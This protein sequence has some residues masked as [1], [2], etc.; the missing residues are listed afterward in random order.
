MFFFETKTKA[1]SLTNFKILHQNIASVLSKQE[2]LEVT[3]QE[4]QKAHNGPDV[5]CL[6]ETFLIKDHKKH[7]NINAYEIAASFC[8]DKQRGGTC[9]LVRKGY[10]INELTYLKTYANEKIFEVCGIELMSHKLI[11]ICLYRTPS[12]DPSVFLNKLD[13]LLHNL[14]KIYKYKINIVIAGDFN[15]N[16]LIKG[17]ITNEL[18]DLSKTYNLKI[19]IDVPTRKSS[20]IDHILSNISD[21]T[22]TVLPLH[23]SDH[24]TAQ[25]LS[26]PVG[27][28][29]LQSATYFIYK[30]DYSL[31]NIRKF[32]ECLQNLSWSEVYGKKDLNIAFSTFHELLCLFYNLCFPKIRIKVHN[33][34]KKKQNWIS[35]GII[36]SCK[37]NGYYGTNIIKIKTRSIKLNILHILIY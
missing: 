19:H 25:L 4:L 21:A 9:I 33:H 23:L 12:S 26:F 1:T 28:K 11:I 37:K 18:Q 17:K 31:D 7:L 36:R 10:P 27:Y 2:I 29:T 20:C 24:D 13:N 30:R 32:R 34:N 22:A 16:T 8:R 5:L 14:H 6:T 3:L 35:Q 15:I